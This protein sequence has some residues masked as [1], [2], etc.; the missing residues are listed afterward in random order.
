MIDFWWSRVFVHPD[1]RGLDYFCRLDTDSAF[2]A[3]VPL[4]IFQSMRAHKH[5]YGYVHQAIDTAESGVIDGLWDFVEEYLEAH[6]DVNDNVVSNEWHL[7]SK[8]ERDSAPMSIYYN[9]FEVCLGRD[10]PLLWTFPL[11]S[12]V[13]GGRCTSV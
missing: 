12:A 4:D 2:V 3:P 10:A 5:V 13:A 9:N 8:A 1:V 7:P 6:P 11:A